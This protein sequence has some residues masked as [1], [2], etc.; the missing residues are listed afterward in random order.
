MG[1]ISDVFR[2]KERTFSCEFFT[3]KTEQ[4]RANL[5]QRAALIRDMVGPDFM[6]VTYGA[7]GSTRGRTTL[8][9]EELQH[10]L[11]LPIMHHLTCVG[12]S[13]E[14]LSSLLQDIEEKGIENI[15]ALRGDPPQGE[16]HWRPHPHGFHY[17]WELCAL[18]RSRGS[19]ATIGVAG[20]PEGHPESPDLPTDIRH[21]KQKLEAGG[22][23]VVTQFFFDNDF[24]YR[25]RD[26]ACE[27][28]I[29]TRIIPGILPVIN[30]ENLLGFSANCG[31][32][33]PRIV[34]DTFAPLQDDPQATLEQG[35]AFAT[36]QCEDLLRN[37]A[38]GIHFY[39]VNKTESI[40]GI[41]SALGL[42]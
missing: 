27:A 24:Y 41:A 35:I 1:C 17:A 37:G 4:G 16:S 36:R 18:I 40:L 6:S 25:F 21:L 38:P 13:K 19:Q 10:N 20:H 14:E 34:H 26:M 15:M 30:Y 28:G 22:D 23:F 8:L 33:L 5:L 42:G 29:R 11:S 2:E 31:A 32:S 3:P 7:G 12:Q 39:T 9:V